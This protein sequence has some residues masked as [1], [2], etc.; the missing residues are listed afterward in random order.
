MFHPFAKVAP[1][2]SLETDNGEIDYYVYKVDS[3]DTVSWTSPKDLNSV[4]LSAGRPCVFQRDDGSLVMYFKDKYVWTETVWKCVGNECWEEPVT[5]TEWWIKRS[6][7]TDQNH[8]STP[9]NVVQ[10]KNT[11]GN[12]VVIEKQDG[13]FIMYYKDKYVWT[14]ENCYW[15]RFKKEWVCETE[16]YTE[17]WIYRRTS[18]DGL[19]WGSAAKVEL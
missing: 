11:T 19:I 3:Q 16:T 17:Y 15:D 2:K 6:I 14:E 8:W 9:Q 7:S 12:P 4:T 5:H 10:V 13:S 18:S 1:Y